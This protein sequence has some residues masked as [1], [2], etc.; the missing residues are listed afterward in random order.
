[1]RP[2]VIRWEKKFNALLTQSERKTFFVEFLIDAVLR[3]DTLAR[4]QAYRIARQD[5]WMN[6]NEIR[7]LENKN[8]IP[9]PEGEEYW[10]PANMVNADEPATPPVPPAIS[11]GNGNGKASSNGASDD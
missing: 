1:M 8:P 6:A 10:R 9:G 2:W 3:G 5:G 4:Y 11:N 7:E